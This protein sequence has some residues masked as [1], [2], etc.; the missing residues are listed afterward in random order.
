[1][2]R[3]LMT[4][5]AAGLAL[6]AAVPAMAG[7]LIFP[8]GT[9]LTERLAGQSYWSTQAQC[10]G[11]F[12]ATSNYLAEKGD[13]AGAEMAK[14]RALGFA[15]DAIKR[16]MKDRG[17]KRPDALQVVQPAILAGRNSGLQAL[18][19]QGMNDN[20]KWNYARS[21]CLDVADIYQSASR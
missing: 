11:L 10:A 14:A 19:E 12:G 7:D 8:G 4:A 17:L 6:S 21:A 20:S 9:G 16:V 13:A 5:L 1:M 18:A 2:K 15:E 3:T